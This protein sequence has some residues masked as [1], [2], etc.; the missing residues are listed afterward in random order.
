MKRVI[1]CYPSSQIVL[2]VAIA[3]ASAQNRPFVPAPA[4]FNRNFEKDAVI[5]KQVF[6]LNPVDNSYV[7]RWVNRLFNVTYSKFRLATRLQ[8][9]WHF[10]D[11]AVTKRPTESGQMSKVSWRIAERKP[12]LKLCKEA[13]P[14]PPPMDSS[15]RF[16][17]SQMRMDSELKVERLK[18]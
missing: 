10:I 11:F 13:T 7:S 8:S 4:V 18:H 1:N 6:D 15:S 5:L 16:A 17:I 9:H 3:Y 2:L 14:T 12:R